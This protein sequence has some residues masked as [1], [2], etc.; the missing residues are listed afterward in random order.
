MIRRQTPSRRLRFA[1]LFLFAL[2]ATP[3]CAAEIAVPMKE[4]AWRVTAKEFRFEKYK[5]KD[6]LYIDNG[7]AEVAD[8]AFENGVIEFDIAFA[9]DRGFSG[10]SFRRAGPKDYEHFY[11][12]PHLSGEPDSSQYTPVFNGVAAWQMMFGPRYA[13]PIEY[14]FDQWMHVKIVVAGGEA[15]IY[16]DSDK[17]SLHVEKLL[18]DPQSGAIAFN[19]SLASARFADLRIDKNGG[20]TI[21]GESPPQAPLEKGVIMEWEISSPFAGARLDGVDRLTAKELNNLSWTRLAV[22]ENGVA[23]I[24]RVAS[25][26]EEADTAFARLVIDS[27]R[28]EIRRL[29]FGF[30]DDVRAYVNGDLVYS[31]ADGY[32]SR[33]YRFLGT[34][35]LYDALYLP[36]KKGRNEVL[37]AVKENFGGWAIMGAL[38]AAGE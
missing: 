24:A 28:R 30:S 23:N 15:D 21:I 16:V 6:S 38:D 9:K 32:A 31:G 13:A 26:S 35:G 18:R 36:L 8:A 17:P 37:F 29:R 27:S 34:V 7:V 10:V 5:G 19:S 11:L 4:D 2:A 3:L 14:R 25:I 20:T 12:R 22:E 1:A 33:D